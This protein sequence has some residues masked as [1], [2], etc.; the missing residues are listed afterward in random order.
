MANEAV[1]NAP[2]LTAR[3]VTKQFPGVLALNQVDLDLPAGQVTALM[4]E[5]GAG[6]STLLKILD[7]DYRPD[8]GELTIAGKR[9]VFATP[10]DARR[11]GLRVIAQEPEI[12]PHV[13]V[14]ENLYLGKLPEKRGVVSQT[15]L[16]RNAAADLARLGF[17]HLLD[18]AQIAATLSPAQRQLVEI[19]RALI[20]EP[21]IVCFDEPTSSL[22]DHEIDALFTAI[23]RMRDEGRAI[24]YVSH[25]M[26]EVF[27]IAD[28]VTVLRDGQCV[29]SRRVD[30][31]T[32][33]DIIQMMVGRDLS[34]MY[35]REP[36][37]LGEEVLRLDH[38]TTDDVSDVSL[39]VRQGEIVALAG[40]VGAGRSEL[41]LAIAGD[42]PVRSGVVTAFGK[43]LRCRTPQDAIRAGIGLAPE[44]RKAD[45]LVLI[46]SVRDNIAL[47]VLGRLSRY[48][49][50]SD[51]K[52]RALAAEYIGRL[53]VRTPSAEQRVENL[54]GGNQQKVVLARWLAKESKVL[55]LD[56][57][58]RGV[59]VGAK[60]EIYSI[61][62]ELAANGAAILMISSELPEVL[63][64]ADRIVVM[65]NGHV[66][67][68]MGR[69][70]ATEE[71][72]LALA[73]AD[74]LDTEGVLA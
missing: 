48:G 67:G 74:E 19:V 40:L 71:K 66:T 17:D 8:Q 44:E 27:Q 41:A 26:R 55:I 29:G 24:A 42:R 65:Q 69:A 34:Q 57:P 62:D 13:T 22:S 25:R 31:V 7:G 45:A 21:Q 3:G 58:T 4:G 51:K 61:I 14:A 33:A 63:G 37:T 30:E 6:K 38:V 1:R 9:V 73:M 47:A 32:Q 68:E 11:A 35:S 49:M 16:R 12:V 15:V 28:R 64:L 43:V 18:P 70:E 23:R 36:R 54:S 56:E 39:H 46:R 53:N 72:I 10:H 2:L 20:D 5:N 60:A 52:E 59:D 50:V